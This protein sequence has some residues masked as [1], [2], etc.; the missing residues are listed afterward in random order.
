M[1]GG[2]QVAVAATLGLT[3]LAIRP[4]E[5]A[6]FAKIAP[7][8]LLIAAVPAAWMLVQA[9]P[10]PVLANPIWAST[11]EALGQPV[12][13][14][15]SIDVGATLVALSRYL[16][17]VALVLATMGLTIDRMRAERALFLLCFVTTLMAAV[18]ILHDLLGFTFLGEIDQGTR[19]AFDSAAAL[20]VILTGGLLNLAVERY[21]TRRG[22]KEIPLFRLVE[23]IS[24]GLGSLVVCGFAASYFARDHVPVAALAGTATFWIIVLIRRIGLGLWA[25]AIMCGITVVALVVVTATKPDGADRDVSLRFA[26]GTE[27][28]LSTVARMLAD[29]R[30]VGTGAGTY[31]ALQAIYREAAAPTEAHAPTTAA[32]VTI[33]LGRPALW[34]G[35]ALALALFG[36][37]L[38]GACERGRDSFYAAAAA[39]CV[40]LQS[41]Q[42]FRDAS[43]LEP[44]PV[45]LTTV[46]VGL[47]LAQR[48]SR[49]LA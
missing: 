9:L 14:H 3:G 32:A 43:L 28:R 37:L 34:I 24:I 15:V 47:G 29:T 48:R 17:A 16:G 10:L 42:A 25:T 8:V 46:I 1:A 36:L 18:I 19:L 21:E 13:R 45:V 2:F 12:L 30:W 23:R 27:T 40:V 33:E 6:H 31:G 4:G 38:R 41:L 35:A 5:A 49:S 7:P 26:S 39:G 22:T 20:G 11:A 44:A